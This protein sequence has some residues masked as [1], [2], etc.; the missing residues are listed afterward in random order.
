MGRVSIFLPQWS[1]LTAHNLTVLV[2]P[3]HFQDE[4]DVF[5]RTNKEKKQKKKTPTRCFQAPATIVPSH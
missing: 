3:H 5:V 4:A 1:V 2:Q